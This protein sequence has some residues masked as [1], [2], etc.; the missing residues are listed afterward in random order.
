MGITSYARST[1]SAL[2]F[3]LA[4]TP[5]RAARF[6]SALSFEKL[7]FSLGRFCPPFLPASAASCGSR[8]KARFSAGTLLPPF[9]GNLPQPSN[10]HARE[11]TFAFR[12]AR[13][14]I[15]LTILVYRYKQQQIRPLMSAI[16]T[17]RTFCA[18]HRMSA[19][20]LSVAPQEP[21]KQEC[22]YYWFSHWY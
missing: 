10:G 11:P 6:A 21:W 4:P 15:L 2:L 13:S 3:F 12:H 18:A 9:F 1:Q 8:E 17:Y 20:L 14:H 16:G 5:L 19:L 22:P 7:R